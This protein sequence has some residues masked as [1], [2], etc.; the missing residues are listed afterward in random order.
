MRNYYHIGLSYFSLV[1]LLLLY[2]FGHAYA[3]GRI[4]NLWVF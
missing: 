1:P 3:T 4:R 2:T